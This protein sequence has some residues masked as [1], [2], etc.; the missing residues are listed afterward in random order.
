MKSPRL[1][2]A[3]LLLAAIVSPGRAEDPAPPPAGPPA[4]GAEAKKPETELD[5]KMEKMNGAF[6]KLRRQAADP[7]KNAESIALV[8][9]LKENATAAAKLVPAKADTIPEADR[10]KFLEGYRSK[11]ADMLAAIDKLAAAFQANQNDDAVKIIQ[12]M[13][14]M[15]KEGHHEYRLP[16]K[17]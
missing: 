17:H 2:T 12:D 5:G 15:Q 8:A 13:G 6:R 1:L 14:A 11:M 10:A 4:A 16:E 3:L 9:T 7:T